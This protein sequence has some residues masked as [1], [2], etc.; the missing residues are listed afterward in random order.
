MAWADDS[1]GQVC[2]AKGPH[3]LHVQLLVLYTCVSTPLPPGLL[4]LVLG[5]YSLRTLPEKTS[6]RFYQK[7]LAQG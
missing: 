5:H 2:V 6:P 4:S 7:I 3:M 1:L